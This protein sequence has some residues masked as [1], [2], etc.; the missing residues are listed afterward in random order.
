M[1]NVVLG[2]YALKLTGSPAFVGLV[3]FAQ[4]G[5]LLFLSTTG[6][7][8]RRHRRPPAAARD[9]RSSRRW[10]LSFALAALVL[11]RRAAAGRDR[12]ARVRDRYRELRSARPASSAILPTLVPREDLPGAVALQSVQMNLSRVIGPAIGGVLYAAFDA[13]PVFAHQRAHVRVR[14]R[15]ADVGDVPAPR[16]RAA[17]TSAACSGCSRASA[18]SAATRCISHVLVTLFTFSFFSLAF[19]GP[20]AGASPRRTSASTRRAPRTGSSTRASASAPRWVRSP[21]GPCSR[22]GRRRGCCGRASSRSRS[23]SPCSR[24]CA[25]PRRR[26]RSARCSATRTSS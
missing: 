6:R 15:R 16:R 23:C 19:V 17:S 12:R 3:F 8:A 26:I 11:A 22:T 7:P 21:S 5:P 24:C 9:R 10:L 18:S 14:D 4:L 2:A 1:Q 20:D 25:T 13:A